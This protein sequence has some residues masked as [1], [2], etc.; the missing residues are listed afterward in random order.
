MLKVQ[1]NYFLVS[2]NACLTHSRALLNDCRLVNVGFYFHFLLM[3]KLDNRCMNA[4]RSLQ[5][6]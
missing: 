5:I 4:S 6:R 1:D 2:I 3:N